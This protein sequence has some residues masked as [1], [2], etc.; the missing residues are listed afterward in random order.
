MPTP[1]TSSPVA[2]ITGAGSGIGAAVARQLLSLGWRV[3]LAGRSGSKLRDTA[4]A[5]SA[6]DPSLSDAIRCVPTDVAD[7]G[8][9]SALIR[10]ADSTFGRIDALINNA[11]E[12]FLAPIEKTGPAELQRSYA[13]NALGPAYAIHSAWPIFTRQKSGRV[14][15]TSTKGTIDPFPGF[16]AY[17]AAKSAVN[18]MARSCAKEG[19]RIG[20]KA[21]AV[22]PG[23]VETGMLR[24]MWSPQQLKPEMCLSPDDVA[25]VI[26]ACAT[27]DRDADNGKTIFLMRE[28][29]GVKETVKD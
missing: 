25:R 8:S 29:G 1:T 19:A 21:F 15:N 22:A 11:G 6:D 26:V 20:V 12:A 5:L 24:S 13:V 3:V 7:A 4:A 14:V 9:V 27:G 17:A 2:I 28:V 10:E 18:S 16:F 23:A